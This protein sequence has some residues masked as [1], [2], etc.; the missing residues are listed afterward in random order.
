MDTPIFSAE[1]ISLAAHLL[2]KNEIVAFPTETVYG[3]GGRLFSQ[4]AIQNIYRIKGRPS[5]N[6]LIVHISLLEDIERLAQEIPSEFYLLAEAFFPGPLTIVLKRRPEIPSMICAGLQSIAVRMPAHPLALELI[7]QVGEP[8]VA[9]SANLSG[10]PSPTLVKHVLQDFQGKI[11]G[12]LD[13]GPCDV[14]IESTVVS[15]LEPQFPLLLRPGKISQEWIEKIL[16]RKINPIEKKSDRS[17]L[18][19]SPGMRYRHYAPKAMIRLFFTSSDY[20]SYLSMTMSPKK[21]MLVSSQKSSR[22]FEPLEHFTLNNQTLYALFR[23][24]DEEDYEEIIVFC[25]EEISGNL[26]LMNRLLK[27]A[28]A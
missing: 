3:L 6:P 16:N 12:V 24:A 26:A 18:L 28:Q 21:K 14:G 9:P 23:Q 27:A 4:E 22:L 15:L 8:L 20:S 25:D 19:A 7:S 11:A 2:R 10:R 17:H 1:D 13:G 5:D